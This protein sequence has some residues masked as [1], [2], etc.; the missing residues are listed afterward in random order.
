VFK[1]K[2]NS[3]FVG[4]MSNL[5]DD[6]LSILRY[7]IVLFMESGMEGARNLKLVLGA[8]ENLPCL[9]INFHKS[10]LFSFVLARAQSHEFC[11]DF[12]E[13]GNLPFWYLGIP[14]HFCKLTNKY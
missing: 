8:F 13:Q 5:V 10:E 1:A 7:D 4:F 2:N 3:Q 12:W 6:S 9:K 14:M 11:R